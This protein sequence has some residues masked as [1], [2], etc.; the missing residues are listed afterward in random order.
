MR[1]PRI[2]RALA[3]G[4]AL[5]ASTG[6]VL[7]AGSRG[8]SPSVDAAARQPAEVDWMAVQQALG[9]PGTMMSGNVFRIG[10]P[11]S[12]LTVTVEGVPVKANFALGSYAA[13]RP[14]ED[15]SGLAMV[16]GDLV[17]RDEEVP[18]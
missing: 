7:V 13:F 12:D 16:M 5:L 14:L 10:M 4:A 18:G 3:Q 11:R 9:R 6:L 17:L 2:A 1:V 8:A 15:G